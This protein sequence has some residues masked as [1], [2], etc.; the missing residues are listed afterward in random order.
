MIAI[1]KN[2]R[3]WQTIL[4]LFCAVQPDCRVEIAFQN[5]RILGVGPPH[6]YP[7]LLYSILLG[8]TCPPNSDAKQRGLRDASTDMEH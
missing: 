5:G 2:G 1:E 8:V 4:E 7:R 6:G 3:P